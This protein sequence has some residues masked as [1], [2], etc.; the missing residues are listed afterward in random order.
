MMKEENYTKYHEAICRKLS[1]ARDDMCQR[2]IETR[3]LFEL[4][5][6][7]VDVHT[8]SDYSDGLGSV[9]DNATVA[10]QMGIDLMFATDHYSIDQ[11]SVTDK[12][13]PKVSWGQEPG[14]G[15]HVGVLEND[16]LL[17]ISPNETVV[18]NLAK[19]KKLGNFAWVAHPIGWYPTTR[20]DEERIA[21]LYNIHYDFG[22]EVLN[23]ANKLA[24][25][26][27]N[28]TDEFVNLWDKLLLNGPKIT[29]VGGSDAHTPNEVGIAWTGVYSDNP[30][31]DSVIQ[32][33]SA[34]HCFAS[35]APCVVLWV[36]EANVG[37]EISQP[38]ENML[39][40]KV[41]AADSAGIAS[42]Q[43]IV[44]GKRTVIL[45]TEDATVFEYECEIKTAE[46]KHFIR[47]EVIASDQLRAFTA[48]IYIKS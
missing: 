12:L 36:N 21:E 20:Y 47:A 19:A 27:E 15:H 3:K 38:Q 29:P 30:A 45:R 28:Y 40:I 11:K 41:R 34:G 24:P 31:S 9:K 10:E 1:F 26:H 43:I 6:V 37:E 13:G 14:A 4:P 32:S 7:T 39:K 8:H 25:R 44:D 48:P 35:Q 18:E 17:E 46:V 42:V 22:M 33:L 2:L 5:I 16:V 23:G